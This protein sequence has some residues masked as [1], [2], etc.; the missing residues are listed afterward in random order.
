MFNLLSKLTNKASNSYNWEAGTSV[1]LAMLLEKWLAQLTIIKINAMWHN[2]VMKSF[3][4]TWNNQILAPF[5]LWFDLIWFDFIIIMFLK[6]FKSLSC[7]PRRTLFD[8]HNKTHLTKTTKQQTTNILHPTLRVS[9]CS[10]I[11]L[12]TQCL[13]HTGPLRPT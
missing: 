3:V 9:G 5:Q 13:V 12:I 1:G 6:Y 10:I 8:I 4:L 11:N 7:V 2:F